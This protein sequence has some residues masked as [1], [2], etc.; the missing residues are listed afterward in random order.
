MKHATCRTRWIGA[1]LVAAT[2]ALPAAARPAATVADRAHD[3]I[4]AGRWAE[5]SALLREGLA[6]C[7]DAECRAR[8]YFMRGY[9]HERR[10]AGAQHAQR[11]RER[12]QHLLQALR[13]YTQAAELAPTNRN[14]RR[15]LA[16]VL[17][18]LGRHRAAAE[19]LEAVVASVPDP[20]AQWLQIGDLRRDAGDPAAALDAYEQAWE[21]A[22]EDP[23]P[24][25][26]MLTVYEQHPQF[27]RGLVE[28]TRDLRDHGWW[29]LAGRA[30]G[31]RLQRADAQNEREELFL[32]WVRL[33]T[34]A[35]TLAAADLD[36]L[37]AA[38]ATPARQLEGVLTGTSADIPWWRGS[39]ER[40]EAIAG[41][42][43][44][45][46]RR[47]ELA[48]DLA[49]ATAAA[50]RVYDRIAP[51][52]EEYSEEELR[53]RRLPVL[54]AAAL[55]ASY[56]DRQGARDRLDALKHQLF[57]DKGLFYLRQNLPGILQMHTV[58]GL[59]FYREARLESDWADNAVFQLRSALEVAAELAER[60]PHEAQPV[61]DLARML[62]E[63]YR[64]L[65]E[66]QESADE[67]RT[68][69]ARAA[70]RYLDAAQSYTD[71][72]DLRSAR[73]ML[74]M[75]GEL[76]LESAERARLETVTRVAAIRR[77]VAEGN[78]VLE[79]GPSGEPVLPD[80]LQ[81]PRRGASEEYLA[82]QRFKIYADV[83]A[84]VDAADAQHFYGTA[85]AAAQAVDRL[86][87]RED[88]RRFVGAV[89]ALEELTAAPGGSRTDREL[90]ELVAEKRRPRSPR[91]AQHASVQIAR[92]P[93]RDPA[94]SWTVYRPGGARAVSISPEVLLAAQVAGSAK[95]WQ[96][97]RNPEFDV[98]IVE[99]RVL[100]QVPETYDSGE[101]ERLM[102][103][104]PAPPEVDVN[105]SREARRNGG[106][107][108]R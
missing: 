32:E 40:R 87:G 59:I 25:R 29:A 99:N 20:H 43:L 8:L 24:A 71:L 80:D 93:P 46:A 26:R 68:L 17:R 77:Q 5:A 96:H 70:A 86:P 39:L 108:R 78:V 33:L 58:L 67:A 97:L 52:L 79:R 12:Q 53:L 19:Q 23:A 13:A 9:L 74:E 36:D 14:V 84:Q 92:R 21:L 55:L 41:A 28:L 95:T 11:E 63:S 4:D 22:W 105:R 42:A 10:A 18:D 66:R 54:D 102:A 83:A 106:G 31:L 65:G 44:L 98:V 2:L 6:A 1:A 3:A 107:E 16:V 37:P 100:V 82:R 49:A 57:D 104:L 15:N 90:L 50:E 62:A 34:R 30:V 60:Y 64:Q 35:D 61:P 73:R 45:R 94:Q 91:Q 88:Q 69:R 48:G 81:P 85:L 72:D 27:S 75:A 103:E 76:P 101:L 56:Y 7:G 51:R 47:Q 38:L 89:A